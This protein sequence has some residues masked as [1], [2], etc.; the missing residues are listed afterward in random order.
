LLAGD[1]KQWEGDTGCRIRQPGSSEHRDVAGDRF[2][3]GAG[4]PALG[5]EPEPLAGQAIAPHRLQ[6]LGPPRVVAARHCPHGVEHRV[7]DAESARRRRRQHHGAVN[8]MR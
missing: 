5:L 8:P 3:I 7:V 6:A 1:G 2:H 4:A